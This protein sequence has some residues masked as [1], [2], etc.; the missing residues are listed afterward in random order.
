VIRAPALPSHPQV[1]TGE[2]LMSTKGH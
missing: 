2:K 1:R